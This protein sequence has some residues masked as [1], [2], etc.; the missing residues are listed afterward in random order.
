MRWVF[1]EEW[2]G[3]APPPW[4]MGEAEPTGEADG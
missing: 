2:P 3:E 4:G 1:A